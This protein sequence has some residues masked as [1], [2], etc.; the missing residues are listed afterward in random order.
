MD[1]FSTDPEDENA[2]S[3]ASVGR[4][5]YVSSIA[6]HRWSLIVVVLGNAAA[7]GHVSVTRSR[8]RA[9]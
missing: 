1:D 7:A 8:V 3:S 5:S 9:A 6:Y 2:G 4:S